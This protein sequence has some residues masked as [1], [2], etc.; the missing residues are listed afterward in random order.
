MS[1][2]LS[3]KFLICLFSAVACFSKGFWDITIPE[4]LYVGLVEIILGAI[5]AGA[6]AIVEGRSDK[7]SLDKQKAEVEL[8][9]AEIERTPVRLVTPG[10][11]P[12][13]PLDQDYEGKWPPADLDGL[14]TVCID[15]LKADRPAPGYSKTEPTAT[16]I[17]GKM[18][19]RAM[20][21][22]VY[23]IDEAIRWMEY[24]TNLA[25]TAFWEVTGMTPPT[26][27]EEIGDIDN[28]LAFLEKERSPAC[29]DVGSADQMAVLQLHDCY[30]ALENLYKLQTTGIDWS[31]VYPQFST[32]VWLANRGDKIAKVAGRKPV[33]HTDRG[34]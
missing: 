26:S 3:R 23:T 9:K 7:A 22:I 6:Y 2:F 24:V 19:R 15:E 1:K 14:V 10:S 34:E 25:R 27:L 33:K 28:Y 12:V 32:P 16:E 11:L 13:P 8:M 4:T 21:Y 29:G 17:F 31:R 20:G 30:E 5:S 18:H